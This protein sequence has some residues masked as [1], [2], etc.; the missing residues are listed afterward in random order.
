[1]PTVTGRLQYDGARTS[2]SATSNPGIAGVTIALQDTSQEATGFGLS[3]FVLTDSSGNFTFTGVPVGNYQLVEAYGTPA[4]ATATVAWSSATTQPLLN[5]GIVPPLIGFVTNP[6]SSATH[7]DCTIRNTRLI[8]VPSGGLAGQ[9]FLNGPVRITPLALEPGIVVDP[10]NLV[11]AADNGT[12]GTFAPGMLANT[13]AGTYPNHP[14]P[15]IDPAFTYVEPETGSGATVSPPDGSYTIQNIMNASHSNTAGTWWRVADHTTGNETGR[16]MVINGDD[17]G[18]LIGETTINVQPN[19]MYISSWWILNLCKIDNGTYINP[20]FSVTILDQTGGVLYEHDLGADIPINTQCPEWKQ[21]GTIID[22]Q[23]NSQL[24]IKF[25]S[26]GG[27]A[28]GND[29]VLDDVAFNRVDTPS[30]IVQKQTCPIAFPSNYLYYSITIQNTSDYYNATQ[31]TLTDALPEE[32]DSVE[33]S[34]DGEN[35]DE[36]TGSLDIDDMAA[37]ESGTLLLRGIVKNGSVGTIGNTAQVTVTFCTSTGN[38][39]EEEV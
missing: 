34:I 9:D 26:Q 23:D 13:G 3:A 38:S 4:S 36:W 27:A 14:Y 24:T 37:G 21:I 31:M 32:L 7:L 8:T 15:G 17:P 5:G 18:Q 6:P 35:W 29:Y 2:A 11:I 28:T 1:M 39:N 20:E 33:Y 10:N 30:L 22:S 12:F 19:T 25:I 16:M